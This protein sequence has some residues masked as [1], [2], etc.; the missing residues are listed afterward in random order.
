MFYG[1]N[2][3]HRVG[4]GELTEFLEKTSHIVLAGSYC[5]SVSY[6]LQLLASFALQP[7]SL[8]MTW[9]G[10]A[11]VTIIL[12][13]IGIIG[14]VRGLKGIE[15]VEQVA[16]GFNMAMIAALLMGLIYYNI[17]AMS[18]GTWHLNH[19]AVSESKV[20][21][22]RL[23]MGMLIIVQGFETSR[24]IGSEHSREE[25]IK[26]MRL[27]QLVSSG[28]YVLFILLMAVVIAHPGGGDKTGIT[29][30]IGFS[31]IV[32]PI[33]PIL[34]TITAIGSQFSAATA[35]D[36]GCSGLMESILE[37]RV[38]AGFGYIIVSIV[39]IA[40]TWL[41]DVYQIINYASRAFAL[42]YALQCM[43]GI[44]VIRKVPLVRYPGIKTFMY[45]ILVFICL[46]VTI[47]GI[48]AG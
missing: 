35:D 7:L 23:L 14:A 26:T 47:F 13:G 6:Y 15:R 18:H 22:V 25:R 4:A 28:I 39:A 2:G 11:L 41:T 42:F 31:S 21:V 27:A 33:L 43:V 17:H 20:H 9:H 34:L 12:T 5:V 46:L 24:F 36:A 32:A 48:P 3:S 44:L 1:F 10:K 38:S 19:N 30:I 16:V 45:G 29:A 37:Q 8:D 40:L